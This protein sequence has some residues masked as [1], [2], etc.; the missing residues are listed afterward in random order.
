MRFLLSGFILFDFFIIQRLIERK[1][2]DSKQQRLYGPLN[3]ESPRHIVPLMFVTQLSIAGG[4]HNALLASKKL[5]METVQAF[6]RK[7]IERL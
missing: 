4:I 5:K 7:V 1:I 3:W 2:R 6:T